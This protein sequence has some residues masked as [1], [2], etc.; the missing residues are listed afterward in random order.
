[1][2]GKWKVLTTI[3]FL[4]PSPPLAL[5]SVGKREGG[6]SL[7]PPSPPL[8]KR[9]SH[10]HPILRT[11]LMA[12]YGWRKRERKRERAMKRGDGFH[13]HFHPASPCVP[14]SL[15]R[16][17]LLDLASSLLFWDWCRP[18]SPTVVRPTQFGGFTCLLGQFLFFGSDLA[19]VHSFKLSPPPPGLLASSSRGKSFFLLPPF[20]FWKSRRKGSFIGGTSAHTRTYVQW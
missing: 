8:A 12:L 11:P 3:Q 20:P 2:R 6:S 18:R 7:L 10:L 15:S 19:N 1:M 5:L 13:F 14:P 4:F 16:K 17:S 9:P